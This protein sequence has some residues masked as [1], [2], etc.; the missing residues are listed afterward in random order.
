[1]TKPDDADRAKHTKEELDEATRELDALNPAG[2]ARVLE[3]LSLDK[4]SLDLLLE[5]LQKRKT[6]RSSQRNTERW[7]L[8]FR[9]NLYRRIRPSVRRMRWRR[10]RKGEGGIVSTPSKNRSPA[11][12]G[13]S[14][15]P[16]PRSCLR[17]SAA[18]RYRETQGLR[19]ES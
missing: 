18:S 10:E 19:A 14:Y 7:S 17:S 12:A 13:R 8:R 4:P 5:L 3:L 2:Q 9:V 16:V 1:M 11:S 6:E 15:V